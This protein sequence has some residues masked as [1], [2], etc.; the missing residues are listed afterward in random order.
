MI[1]KKRIYT[2]VTFCIA[3]AVAISIARADQPEFP[4]LMSNERYVE[5][6]AKND[7]LMFREDSLQRVIAEVREEFNRNRRDSLITNE[8]IDMFTSH[9]LTLE[10]SIFEIRQ[11]RG[12]VITEINDIEQEYILAHMYSSEHAEE[13]EE[14]ISEMV[15]STATDSSEEEIVVRSRSLYKN[16]TFSRTL[17]TEDYA[18]LLV[19]QAEDEALEMQCKEYIDTYN[20]LLATVEEYRSTDSESVADSLFSRYLELKHIAEARSNDIDLSWNHIIDTK[21]YALGYVLER[22]HRYDALDASSEAFSQMQQQCSELDGNYASDA[23]MHYAIGRAT[24]LDYEILSAQEFGLIE[25]LD[26]LQQRR[27]T[28][29]DIDYRHNKV[30]LERRLFLDYAPIIIGRSNFYNST[31]R[32]PELKVYERGT[33]YRILLGTFKSKQTMTLFKGVQPLFI[34]QNEEGKYSY[35]AGGFATLAEAEEAQLF[36]KEK[37]FKRPEICRWRDGVMTNLSQA[38][39]DDGEIDEVATSSNRYIVTLECDSISDQMR[40][41]ISTTAPDKMISRRG[42]QFAIGT[43]TERSEAD[44]LMSSIVERFPD[45]ET[46]IVELDIQ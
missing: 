29:S 44:L 18:E 24:L 19:A 32:L 25:A 27:S 23:V 26:S 46:S 28:L 30:Q 36:L 7:S 17:A 38:K 16:D 15:D 14:A 31:N 37:G 20:A 10:E 1:A 21:Y 41:L 13:R 33:I 3:T 43:F 22:A 39:S 12:D 42:Q 11:Q 34:D 4:E 35:Y 9:I 8:D 2:F 6:R 45:I 5:L 40:Q